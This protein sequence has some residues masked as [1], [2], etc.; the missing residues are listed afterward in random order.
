MGIQN[1]TVVAGYKHEVIPR[2]PFHVILNENYAETNMVYTLFCAESSIKPSHDILII[3]GDCVYETR[4]VQALLD[5]DLDQAIAI[6]LH[7]KNYW[8]VRLDNPLNDAETL[9]LDDDGYVLELGKK[10][11]SYDQIQGQYMGL[12]KFQAEAWEEACSFY[13]Q[14]PKDILYDGQAFN[15]MYMTSFL[16]HLIDSGRSIKAVPVHGGWLEFDSL[17]DLNLYEQMHQN[18][19]LDAFFKV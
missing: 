19:Q 9:R 2:H 13:H 14:L 6:D 4:V 3:Y 1:I 15:K 17:T 11:Q 16:Q 18:K 7:W 12:I 5:A 8:D 10:P